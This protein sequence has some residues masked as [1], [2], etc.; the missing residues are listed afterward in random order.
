MF[1]CCN[2]RILNDSSPKLTVDAALTGRP[3]LKFSLLRESLENIVLLYKLTKILSTKIIVCKQ[4][5]RWAVDSTSRSDKG[6]C[7][8][9][10]HGR[11]L[12]RSCS[13]T[14]ILIELLVR[15]ISTADSLFTQRR[16]VLV[17]C[18]GDLG[19]PS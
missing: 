5:F 15:K 1:S 9:S 8:L 13:R 10:D 3:V 16:A 4:A 7:P 14:N 12:G 6:T 19:A 17:S 2:R 18:L 11:Y